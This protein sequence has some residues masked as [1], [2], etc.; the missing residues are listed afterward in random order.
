[1]YTEH[2]DLSWGLL[3]RILIQLVV[4][5]RA[6]EWNPGWGEAMQRSSSDYAEQIWVGEEMGKQEMAAHVGAEP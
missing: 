3:G 6:G 4:Q 2:P 5:M 1:M